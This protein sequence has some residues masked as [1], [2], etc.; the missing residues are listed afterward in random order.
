MLSVDAIKIDQ[1]QAPGMAKWIT[2]ETNVVEFFQTSENAPFKQSRIGIESEY[3]HRR[4]FT[5]GIG[6]S[7]NPEHEK[8]VMRL[9]GVAREYMRHN[10]QQDPWLALESIKI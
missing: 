10:H 8:D 3:F 7:I 5:D 6:Y 4:K 9:I 1:V 2:G